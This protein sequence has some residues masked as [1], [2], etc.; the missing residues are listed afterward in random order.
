MR[1]KDI[2]LIEAAEEIKS[3]RMSSVELTDFFLTEI[4]RKNKR[5]NSFIRILEKQA[6]SEALLADKR[7]KEV[8]RHLLPLNG[9]PIAIKDLFDMKGIPTTCGSSARMNYVPCRNSVIVQRLLNAGAIIL[10]KLNLHEFAF[11]PTSENEVFGDVRNPWNTACIAGGSSG[12]SAAAVADGLCLGALGTD[13]G[14]SIRIPAALCGVVGIKPTANCIDLTGVFPLSFTLDNAGPLARNVKDATLLLSIILDDESLQKINTTIPKNKL[15]KRC[16]IGVVE[17]LSFPIEDDIETSFE[18]ACEVMEGF[19]RLYKVQL[20]FLTYYKTFADVIMTCE[21]SCIHESLLRKKFNKYSRE[22]RTKIISGNFFSSTE[23]LQAIQMK[24]KLTS[25]L[26]GI[27]RE[28]DLLVLPTTPIVATRLRENFI[29]LREERYEVNYVLG[30]LTRPF[31][32]CGLPAVSVPSGLS[33]KGLPIGLQIVGKP[34]QD[35]LVLAVADIYEN[36][37]GSLPSLA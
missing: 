9:V 23:Y 2:T 22:V 21:A 16:K 18:K 3:G 28:F 29:R 8:Q 31:S 6:R 36:A 5:T 33:A 32:L 35:N 15:T 14:G 4:R 13:T 17:N 30:I 1:Y 27:M 37:R 7:A 26:I 12:G 20:P 10:G 11:G 19:A 25:I 24:R 34:Y